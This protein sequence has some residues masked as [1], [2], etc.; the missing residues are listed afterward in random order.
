MP[1]KRVVIV[2]VLVSLVSH[3]AILSLTG[4][5]PV[6]GESTRENVFTM[7][8]REVNTAAVENNAPPPPARPV[9]R[10]AKT[11]RP[12]YDAEDAAAASPADV[13]SVREETV[14]LDSVDTPYTPYLKRLREKI[15]RLWTYPQGAAKRQEVGTTVIRFSVTRNGALDA[16]ITMASSGYPSVDESALMAVRSA[17]PFDTL[18]ADLARLTIIATFR[19]RIEP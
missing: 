2:F 11:A 4:I 9:S 19:S 7:D 3:L 10:A 13:L 5:L 1:S 16:L 17:A 15:G 6:R 12:G 18:P 14:S 8:L